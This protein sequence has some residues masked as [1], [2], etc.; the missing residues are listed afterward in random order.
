M[1]TFIRAKDYDK[2]KKGEDVEIVVE[3][4]NREPMRVFV[5]SISFSTSESDY[6]NYK[7]AVFNGEVDQGGL[8]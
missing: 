1:T 8:I 2:I 5:S 4:K 3:A 7:N 6:A